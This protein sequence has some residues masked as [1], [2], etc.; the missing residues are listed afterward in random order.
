MKGFRQ[1]DYDLEI[2]QC[3]SYFKCQ[4][5]TE[6]S[7]GFCQLSQLRIL[8]WFICILMMS[9]DILKFQQVKKSKKSK[10]FM[11]MGMKV[12]TKKKKIERGKKGKNE[13]ITTQ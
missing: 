10:K 3:Q 7:L 13:S 8:T 9:A 12:N 1:H 5:Q 4:T 2:M 11:P 6:L